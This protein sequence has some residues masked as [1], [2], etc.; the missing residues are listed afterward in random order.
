M[1][2]QTNLW[3]MN[4]FFLIN[5]SVKTSLIFSSNIC[6]CYK[7]NNCTIINIIANKLIYDHAIIFKYKYRKIKYKYISI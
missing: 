4:S 5:E 3:C 1:L 7:E 2:D 6:H